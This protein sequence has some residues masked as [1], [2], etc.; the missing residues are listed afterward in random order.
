MQLIV[1]KGHRYTLDLIRCESKRVVVIVVH[2]EF[3]FSQD[4]FVRN[5]PPVTH[6]VGVYTTFFSYFI[7]VPCFC[8]LSPVYTEN[9]G[10]EAEPLRR[11][12]FHPAVSGFTL[13]GWCVCINLC[14]LSRCVLMQPL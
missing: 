7:Q 6:F 1:E 11:S 3:D 14:T 2:S 13:M 4:T 10:A 8:A 12:T 5:A 9:C